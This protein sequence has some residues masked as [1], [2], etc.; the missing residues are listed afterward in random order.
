MYKDKL[1]ETTKKDLEGI[2]NIN[3]IQGKKLT[4]LIKT[5]NRLELQ[6]QKLI[7]YKYFENRNNSEI[8]RLLNI[9]NGTVKRKLDKI[10]LKVGR[11]MYGMEEEF[12]KELII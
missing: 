11:A 4:I 12:W 9:S 8:G 3:S 7:A 6:E 5:L 2:K 10:I 1:I